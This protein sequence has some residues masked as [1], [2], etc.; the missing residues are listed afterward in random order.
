VKKRIFCLALLAAGLSLP[1]AT[2]AKA[3]PHMWVGFQ[4]DASFRWRPD[5]EN[6]LD[7]ARDAGATIVRAWAYWPQIAPTRPANAANPFDP[8]YHFD[9][10]DELVRGTQA[11]GME[12]LLTPWGTPKW[13]NGKTPN[14]APRNIRDWSNFV[15]ALALRYSGRY[16]GYPAVRFWSVWNEPNL[17]QFLAPQFVGK[18]DASPAIYAK[19]YRA[20]YTAIKQANPTAEVA[21]G[22]TS[23]RGRD[24]PLGSKSTQD[25]HSPGKFAQLLAAQ[26]PLLKFDAWA[27]H[28]YA[29]P[30]TAPVTQKVRWPNVSLSSMKRF[31]TSI[32]LWFHRKSTP[33]WITEYGYQTKP[34][35]SA[36]GVSW[37]TQAANVRTA[38]SIVGNDPSIQMFIWFT[39]RDDAGNPWKS[40]VVANDNSQKPSLATFTTTAKPM[41]GR[42]LILT[43]PTGRPAVVR[44][45]AREL[46]KDTAV[47]EPVGVTYSLYDGAQALG[48]HQPQLTMSRD[49]WLT[50]PLELTPVKGHTYTVI[51]TANAHGDYIRR[52]LTLKTS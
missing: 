44:F 29:L 36:G 12:V 35:L 45:P 25:T 13:A 51:I 49:S 5:R 3:A 11:R 37:A 27:H 40:G 28:P 18:K 17:N 1:V 8:A 52:Q 22:E 4:D 14:Y 43:V 9:D 2:A 7:A 46:A 33:M 23:P 30:Q 32:D 19:L 47:G 38:L 50:L 39:F 16:P 41:D 15:Q 34:P 31:E 21:I 26:R 42:D 20:A 6:N 24:K 48:V 10:I